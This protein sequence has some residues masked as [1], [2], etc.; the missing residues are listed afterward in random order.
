[1]F[2]V[3]KVHF[4]N[5][6][7]LF[8]VAEI[9]YQCGKDMAVKY[10]L[11][12]WDNSHFKTWIIVFICLLKNEIYLVYEEKF[13]VATFQTRKVKRSYLFQK[14]AT[15]PKSSGRGVGTF[16]L[17]EIER[18]GRNRGCTELLCEV[19]QK[20]LHAKDFYIRRGFEIYGT[21]DTLKY[22]EDKL[23]KKL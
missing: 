17:N 13:P 5:I 8:H 22:S 9:L 6:G 3:R 1:M 10:S 19:Y 2:L 18:M 20:S 11:H 15:S 16:C 23:R 4:W 14:L 12:H 7:L 21:T